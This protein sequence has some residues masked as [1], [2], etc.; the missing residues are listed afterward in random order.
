M[1]C[2]N[3]EASGTISKPQD[4]VDYIHEEKAY[5]ETNAVYIVCSAGC[6]WNDKKDLLYEI[7]IGVGDRVAIEE[8]GFLKLRKQNLVVLRLKYST[9]MAAEGMIRIRSVSVPRQSCLRWSE[10]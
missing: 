1:K 10:R 2:V 9:R 4:I 8:E 5:T 3:F 7:K 6:Y